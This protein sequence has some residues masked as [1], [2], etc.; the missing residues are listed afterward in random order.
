MNATGTN[1]YELPTKIRSIVC[2]HLGLEVS[3]ICQPTR[4][5]E[6]VNARQIAM[7]FIKQYTQLSLAEIGEYF[8]HGDHATVLHSVRKVENETSIYHAFR[9]EMEIL[10]AK[11]RTMYNNEFKRYENY[12]TDNV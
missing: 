6:L 4:R 9:K 7:Y 12:E 3:T 5:R 8:P 11:I 1:G 2:N 10:D